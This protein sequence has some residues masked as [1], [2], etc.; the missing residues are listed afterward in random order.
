MNAINKMHQTPLI[1]AAAGKQKKYVNMV[2]ALVRNGAK[3]N[4]KVRGDIFKHRVQAVVL[5]CG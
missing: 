1:L 2:K 4:A 3:V 5:T